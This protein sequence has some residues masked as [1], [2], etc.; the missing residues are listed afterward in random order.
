[1]S[2]DFH[3][4]LPS[5]GLGGI[6][7]TLTPARWICVF[8]KSRLGFEPRPGMPVRFGSS[9]AKVEGV[10]DLG[11]DWRITWLK[12]GVIETGQEDEGHGG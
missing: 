8:P 3:I 9:Y 7:G 12:S 6:K 5:D 1:M 4:L 2:D 11:G 10:E